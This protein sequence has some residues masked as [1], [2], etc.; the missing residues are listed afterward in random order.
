MSMEKCK[1]G[2][3]CRETAKQN[4]VKTKKAKYKKAYGIEYFAAEKERGCEM[5]N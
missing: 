2:D 3:G 5:R 1:R 4:G